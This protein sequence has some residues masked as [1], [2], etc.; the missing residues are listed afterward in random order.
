[1]QKTL[2]VDLICCYE[3]NSIMFGGKPRI[4]KKAIFV[5]TFYSSGTKFDERLYRVP[6]VPDMPEVILV[7]PWLDKFNIG[8]TFSNEKGTLTDS[9]GN[10]L[11]LIKDN[12]N[13]V[14]EVYKMT[15]EAYYTELTKTVEKEST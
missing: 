12:D 5:D 15:Y 1:M 14:E 13:A 10:T 8:L 7:L 9:Q 6:D 3:D 2:G 11:A 4:S